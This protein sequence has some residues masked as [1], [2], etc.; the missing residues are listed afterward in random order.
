MRSRGIWRLL[1]VAA[2]LALAALYLFPY[3]WMVLTAI[4]P[5][6]EFYRFPATIFPEHVTFQP[7]VS[8]MVARG[9]LTLLRNSLVICLAA[10]AVGL[11][12]S[13]LIAYPVT[14]LPVSPRFRRALL[15]WILS[16]RF[17]P[18]IVVVI[19]FFD[20]V[21][22]A[23][24]YDNPLSLM[25]LYAVF[26]LPFATWMLR[27]FLLEVPLE[28]EEAALV[29]GATRLRA[30]FTILLPQLAPALLATAVITFALSWS[31]FMFAFI[32]SATPRSQTFPIGVASLVTQ[33]EI[34]WNEMAAVGTVASAVPVLLLLLARRYV[35][36][37][38][39]FGA[40]R[41]KA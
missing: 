39:T 23:G 5:L 32:L 29:D 41:E 24:L 2:L 30:F 14:R 3:F 1:A 38:L 4:K 18:P 25:L 13:L 7:F 6:P 31:E 9:Y 12:V 11:V 20:I 26:S 28:L 40:I 19:P 21:R 33:F 8:V 15:N 35:L 37:A 36:T 27:G 10:V 22:H 34:I 16:L 17:L